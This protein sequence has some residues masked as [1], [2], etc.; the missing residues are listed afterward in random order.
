MKVE[1]VNSHRNANAYISY[2]RPS[3]NGDSTNRIFSF[4]LERLEQTHEI[5]GQVIQA[6]T[7]QHFYARNY[8]SGKLALTGRVKT[9]EDYDQ[10]AEFVRSHQ[11]LM[12]N[13]S[14]GADIGSKLLPLM[15]LGIASENLYYT[16]WIDNFP[17]GAKRFNP[18]PQFTTQ[19]TVASDKHSTNDK[20]IP[21]YLKRATFTG[22]FL[23]GPVFTP[24]VPK[25]PTKKDAQDV[26]DAVGS[27]ADAAWKAIGGGF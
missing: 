4:W 12:V 23:D 16:G 6:Q 22:A 10:L 11:L 5:N 24:D 3:V 27:V 7:Y 15:K 25:A 17:A 9:Q 18:A 2:V 20:I 1:I 19:F 8:I 26:I 13:T 14:G 21:S